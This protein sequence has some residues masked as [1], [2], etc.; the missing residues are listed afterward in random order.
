MVKPT[1]ILNAEFDNLWQM[2]HMTTK[3]KTSPEFLNYQFDF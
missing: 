1:Y 2:T 3:K